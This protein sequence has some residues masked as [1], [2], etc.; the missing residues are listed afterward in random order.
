MTGGAD[1]KTALFGRAAETAEISDLIDGLP[2]RGRALVL[3]GE[4]GVGKTEL[5]AAA[6]RHADVNGVT[7][8]RTVGIESESGLPFAGLHRLLRPVADQVHSLPGSYR[9]AL[10]AAFGVGAATGED[11]FLVD[12]ATLDVLSL[13]SSES[14]V[15]A[16]IDD[17][18]WVDDMTRRALGFVS[19]R[20]ESDPIGILIT[21]RD[22]Y[23][24]EV[25][26]HGLPTRRVPP[27][28]SAS[29]SALLQARNPKLSTSQQRRILEIAAGNP[30]AIVELEAIVAS[31]GASSSPGGA[32][33]LTARLERAFAA[34]LHHVP[35]DTRRLLSIAA[36]DPSLE[37]SEL[38]VAGRHLL[39]RPVDIGLLQP[40]VRAEIVRP[41]G[42]RLLFRHPLMRSA[43]YG[44]T[45]LQDRQAVHRVLAATL[46]DP[47]RRAQHRSLATLQRDESVA[48][49]V[50]AL[51]ARMRERGAILDA[52]GAYGRAAELSVQ[53]ESEARRLLTGGELAFHAGRPDLVER[54]VSSAR[55][56]HLSPLQRSQA[57]W[58]GEV[59]F[60]ARPSD[61]GRIIELVASA[62][63]AAAA[64]NSTLALALLNAAA[65]R[66]FWYEPE[67]E[68][69]DQIVAGVA[70]LGLPA[71]DDR[72]LAII[73]MADPIGRSGT[74]I[75]RVRQAG[76]PE[77]PDRLLRLALAS[78]SVGDWGT[79]IQLA[80][81]A[82]DPLR[83]HGRLGLLTHALGMHTWGSIFSGRIQ[84]ASESAAEFLRIADESGQ[85][86]WNA[87]AL[88]AEGTL[89]GI[90]G[91]ERR[92]HALL[93]EGE[94]LLPP[95]ATGALVHVV[96]Y[97]RG[98]TALST[99]RFEDAYA[100]LSRRF[101]ETDPGHRHREQ[102]HAISFFA[103]AALATGHRSRAH[104]IAADLYQHAAP[105]VPRALLLGHA[106][107]R[108]VL[109]DDQTAEAEFRRARDTITPQW[110]FLRAR[111]DL[112]HG[113]WLRR[114]QRPAESRTP[115]RDARDAFDR[116][117]LHW[118]ADRARQE[119]RASGET[120]RP[121]QP[122][123]WDQ[124][125]PQELQIARLAATGLTN[126]EIGQRLYLSHRTISSHLYRIF[127]KLG[128]TTRAQL[129]ANLP[130][131]TPETPQRPSR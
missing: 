54:L 89:C 52:A 98:V 3:S 55:H 28:D 101:D 13:A 103:D 2:E 65:L 35:P 112:T 60:D 9:D 85:P 49:D 59:S 80:Q 46:S 5:L 115:L 83:M 70:G 33:Q 45:S 109:A 10:Q 116:M 122:E 86:M 97:G 111:L 43:T 14:P 48:A 100:Q 36:A 18:Q 24:A 15:L 17:L 71:T 29:A 126:R 47:D 77:E 12:C 129:A 94:Q 51:G 114:Q 44:Q 72:A 42:M 119:L 121:R 63:R 125:S 127:P 123:A 81:R 53:P 74:V 78:H 99:G 131:L 40:A 105:Q 8:L 66:S 32:L 69:R 90:K 67:R 88:I 104:R 87:G 7:I 6:A 68:V 92:A 11:P 102:H 34:R 37:I 58:L 27:L 117:R 73:S 19:R 75:D 130:D 128:I 124:L 64:G 61:P 96:A 50:E 16:L 57:D 106:Y 84:L 113:V 120:S 56:L 31:A 62:Q 110:T 38:L 21:V 76:L 23:D 118:W 93:D 30:L 82:I 107:A 1:G 95:D 22:G 20:I 108:A 26:D 4:P 79:S 25:G 39:N 41:A 91:D